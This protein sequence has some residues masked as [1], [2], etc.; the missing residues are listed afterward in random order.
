MSYLDLDYRYFHN[1]RDFCRVYSESV[2]VRIEQLFLKHRISY[3]IKEEDSSLVAKLFGNTKSGYVIR[4][5][6]KDI[7]LADYLVSGTRGVEVITDRVE[8]D[9]SPKTQLERRRNRGAQERMYLDA[10]RQIV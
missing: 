4:I 8:E 7:N 10:E 5:N 1:E 6:A 2:L 9:W 3:F